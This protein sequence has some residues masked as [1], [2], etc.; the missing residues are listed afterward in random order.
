MTSLAELNR[1]HFECVTSLVIPALPIMAVG[2][3]LTIKISSNEAS[4]YD[5]KHEQA[6]EEIARRIESRLDFIGVNWVEDE[7]SEDEGDKPDGKFE[8]QVRLLDYACGT[9]SMSRVSLCSPNPDCMSLFDHAVCLNT[10]SKERCS[11]LI[12]LNASALTS[13]RKWWKFITPEL[14]TRLVIYLPIL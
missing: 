3:V 5:S 12:P 7:S 4:H 14:Q 13:R 10:V 1:A 6:T 11:R 9:G 2:A 8:R